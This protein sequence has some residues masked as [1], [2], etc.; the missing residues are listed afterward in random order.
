MPPER[1]SCCRRAAPAATPAGRGGRPAPGPSSS[2]PATDG[3]TA[4]S[5]PSPRSPRCSGD[6]RAAVPG[7]MDNGAHHQA[8]VGLVQTR[9]HLARSTGLPSAMLAAISSSCRSLDE[10]RNTPDSTAWPA[11][12][13]S[14]QTMAWPVN[15]C[16]PNPSAAASAQSSRHNHNS[17]PISSS[18][19]ACRHSRPF[20]HTRKP[21]TRSSRRVVS[22]VLV[23]GDTAREVDASS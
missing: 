14:S 2:G 16:H 23:F 19:A 20:A 7:G 18:T 4:R 9:Q 10:H 15:T 12:M 1:G 6:D 5:S 3:A 8:G 17:C 22:R 21:A 11:A 13:K